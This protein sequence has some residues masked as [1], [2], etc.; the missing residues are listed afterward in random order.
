MVKPLSRPRR[1]FWG[2]LIAILDF[3]GGTSAPGAARLVFFYF[4]YF[5]FFVVNVSHKIAS[6]KKKKLSSI[7]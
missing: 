7:I 6:L 2:P 4:Y 1:L 5:F 3:A